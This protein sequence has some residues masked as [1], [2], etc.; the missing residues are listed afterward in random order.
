M[1]SDG[2]AMIHPEKVLAERNKMEEGKQTR[3]WLV[4][5]KGMSAEDAMWESELL[6]KSQFP[7]FHL[8]D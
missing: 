8:E 4:H 2:A 5:W 1:E 6:L 7:D 3:E